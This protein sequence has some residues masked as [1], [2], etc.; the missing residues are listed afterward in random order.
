MTFLYADYT[1]YMHPNVPAPHNWWPAL[2]TT[3][4]TA[5]LWLYMIN[6]PIRGQ[7]ELER[8]PVELLSHSG[9]FRDSEETAVVVLGPSFLLSIR[10]GLR[11]GGLTLT[12]LICACFRGTD[13]QIWNEILW[14]V[15]TFPSSITVAWCD[16]WIK[17][18][19]E[20]RTQHSSVSRAA[21]LIQF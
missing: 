20:P 7:P 21:V 2:L 1:P 16:N 15:K 13:T 18:R 17:L 5:A 10:M 19:G 8:G 3:H 14:H 6:E 9:E 12:P 11:T 4:T